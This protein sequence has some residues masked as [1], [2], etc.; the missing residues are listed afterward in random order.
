L[1][2]CGLNRWLKVEAAAVSL[3]ARKALSLCRRQPAM[4]PMRAKPTSCGRSS[5][6]A[7]NVSRAKENNRRMSTS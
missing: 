7:S 3:F 2:Y 6:A 4:I 1:F 5:S